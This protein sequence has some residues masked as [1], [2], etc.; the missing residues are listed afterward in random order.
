MEVEAKVLEA[1][2]LLRQ[3]GRMDFLKDGALAPGR[4]ARR[5]SAGVA[6]AVAA[7]SPPRVAGA[8]KVRGVPRGAGA[9]GVFGEGKGRFSGQE[10]GRGSPRVSRE[11]GHGPPRQSCKRARKGKAGPQEA[12]RRKG[13]RTEGVGALEASAAG[14]SEGGKADARQARAAVSSEVRKARGATGGPGAVATSKGL[15]VSGRGR[16]GQG[17]APRVEEARVL[18]LGIRHGEGEKRGTAGKEVERDPRVP[19]SEKWPTMLQW[20][21]D[22]VGGSTE[23]GKWYKGEGSV[24]DRS[25]GAPRKEYRSGISESEVLGEDDGLDEEGLEGEEGLGVRSQWDIGSSPG[26]PDLVWQGPL[27]YEDDDPGKQDAARVHWEEGKAGPGAASWMASAGWSRRRYGAAD[28]FSG[29]CG[30]EGIAPPVAAGQE[31]QHPGPQCRRCLDD[32]SVIQ[33]ELAYT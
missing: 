2:A 23:G 11:A 27:D 18:E 28:A 30:G 29:L 3:A 21:S 1:V 4:P 13:D 14:K 5:A 20:S 7:C 32:P 24:V 12:A 8:V 9:K 26:T 6:A 33:I 17:G 31:E 10:R 16:R 19:M 25:L 22:E 15:S